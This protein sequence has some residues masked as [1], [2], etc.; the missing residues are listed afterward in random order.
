MGPNYVW[1]Q[2][3]WN[4]LIQGVIR[5]CAERVMRLDAF[6]HV[7]KLGYVTVLKPYKKPL[8]VVSQKKKKNL[9]ITPWSYI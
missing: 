8:S 1:N 9:S 4:S 7:S 2:N 6:K 3:N 5:D